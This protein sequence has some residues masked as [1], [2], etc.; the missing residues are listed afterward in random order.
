MKVSGRSIWMVVVAVVSL[1]V[2]S[3]SGRSIWMVLVAVVSLI[4][5]LGV[6][7]GRVAFGVALAVRMVLVAVVSVGLV[8][9]PIAFAA[10]GSV[11]VMSIWI[12]LPSFGVVSVAA[13]PPGTSETTSHSYTASLKGICESPQKAMSAM[14]ATMP[15]IRGM[16]QVKMANR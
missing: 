8:S 15:T 9:V 3:V 13:A 6:L 2:V 16:N 10:V 7:S 1:G 4:V 11:P 5:S 14:T 12:G